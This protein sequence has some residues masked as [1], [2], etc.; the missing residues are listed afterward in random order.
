[1]V[2]TQEQY[3]VNPTYLDFFGFTRPPFA[4]FADG[5]NLY[6][7]EQ[8][9]L[10]M[11]HLA[12]AASSGDSLVVLCGADGSGKS[13]LLNRFLAGVDEHTYRVVIDENCHEEKQFYTAFLTQIGFQ[14]ITGTISELRNITKEF[15][16]CRGIARDH[17]LI[18][19]DNAHLT[20]PMILEQLKWLCGVKIKDRRAL[21]IVLAGNANIIRVVD[22]PAMRQI[23]FRKH[24]VFGIRSY[25]EEETADYVWHRLRLAGGISGVKLPGKTNS[26][27]HRYSGGI[28]R[29]I[30][31]L[32]D[33][34]LAE[35]HSL[36]SRVITEDMVRTAAKRLQL[37]PHVTPFHGKGRRKNDPDFTH[38]RAVPKTAVV[39][40]ERLSQEIAELSEQLEDLRADKAQ[41]IQDIDSR[42]E[43]II[44]LREEFDSQT[45]AVER[46][47][48]SLASSSDE[49]TQKNLA[50]TDKD[51][52]LQDSENR[53]KDLATE[54]EKE[55]QAREAAESELAKV[56]ATIEELRQL[57]TEFRTTVDNV[58]ADLEAGL[59]VA[60]E[61]AVKIEALEKKV[62]DLNDE[63]EGKAA[64]LDSLRDEL[65]LRNEAFAD[66]ESRLA[67]TQAECE[68]AHRRIA[69]LI[70]P[71]ELDEI[72][73]ASD[74]LA[75]DLE[76]E[77]QAREA[78]ERE[79]AKATATIEE[80][81]H[82][83]T[84]LRTTVDDAHSDLEAGL[85]V[86]DEHAAKIE[87]LEKTVS[88]LE[89]EIESKTVEVGSL[90]DE[91]ISRNEILTD[92][93]T[94][95]A[96]S[97]SALGLAQ[98]R[99]LKLK[100]PKELKEIKRASDRLAADLEK[101]A[102]AR[103]AAESELAQAT[104]TIEEL[105]QIKT[106]LQT[107]VDD[108][109]VDLEAGLKVANERAAE[110]EGLEKN[111]SDLEDE[112]KGKAGEL[113]SLREE[114]AADLA[115]EKRAREAAENEL[116]ESRAAVEELAQLERD[117]RASVR[118][119][120]ADLSVAGEKAIEAYVL[121][122]NVADLTDE[123]ESRN[124]AFA[125]L[126]MQLEESQRECEL[127]RRGVAKVDIDDDIAS[128][129]SAE[130]LSPGTR[131]YS[132]PVVAKFVESISN[133]RAYQMLQKFDPVFFDGLVNTYEKLVGQSL[134]DKQVNDALRA[135]Q[136][137]LMGQL[138]PRASDDAIISYAE[139]IVD[140]LD[141]FQLYGTEPC[142][143]LLVPP[144]DPDTDTSPIYSEKTKER[145]L[146]TLDIIL[147]TYNADKRL[148]AQEDVWPDLDPIFAGL[149]DAF[150]AD[151]V[152]A[153]ENSYDPR[154]DRVLVCN[155]SRALYSGVLQ[156]PKRK[157][158][159]ALRWLLAP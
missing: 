117:L 8:Y 73:K 54:L 126:E 95:L 36:E 5:S 46:L 23:K 65:A 6:A 78:A 18:I 124:Q 42:N 90:Q 47:T 37:L 147:R 62:S 19:I 63:I 98:Q 80:L 113:A 84:E 22:A 110:I 16:V 105:R 138:L 133:I 64:E 26:A 141:E 135:E 119:L 45:T 109:Q 11:E 142:L 41:A 96:Q 159:N 31:R 76:K 129:D 12:N 71:E 44:A 100:S 146:E 122:R 38:I 30:N 60:D 25:S 158:V 155:V 92:L 151:N 24:V 111:L 137:I 52:A 125:N 20:D 43:E 127:L 86:S 70:D 153:M 21:S 131:A 14:E 3:A 85:K 140:Q 28:P 1:M 115:H 94:R 79:L 103:E 134:S 10:L 81:H 66:V 145:E 97:Q 149:F 53:I 77:I 116:A 57:K 32:C 118:D 121:A 40:T 9:S 55:I 128:K 58:Q 51:M 34:M 93:E 130:P 2:R 104:A 59:T 112:V 83:K 102:Q 48:H 154:I 29:L 152:A 101:E 69:A 88:N 4:R 114:L 99:M 107:T 148:P 13:T 49:I 68:A 108:V 87:A 120:N 82:L 136:A 7:S 72:E 132:S 61:R 157:A 35:A 67:E 17:V 91:L 123:L 144:S 156:L 106:E 33:K 27:I 39:D 74:Q 139:L 89:D 143:K 50:L 15:L 56:T 75:A 150:G